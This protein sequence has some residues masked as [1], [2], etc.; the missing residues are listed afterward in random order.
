MKKYIA[1]FIV[2]SLMFCLTGCVHCKED[3][4]YT[5]EKLSECL[6]PDLP[7]LEVSFLNQENWKIYANI[8]DAE[9]ETYV[10]SV[11]D[12]LKSQNFAYLGTRGHQKSSLVG[13]FA[14]YYFQPAETLEQHCQ[15]GVYYFIYSDGSTDE[16][17]QLIFWC[18][19]IYQGSSYKDYDGK[20][21]NYNT[22]LLLRKGGE[23]PATG[24]YYYD[25]A[26][27]DPC[28]FKCSYDEGIAYPI[29]GSEETVTIRTCANCGHEDYSTFAG[30]MTIY[31]LLEADS[32]GIHYV[33][34]HAEQAASGIL[35]RIYT[36]ALL[37]ADIILTVNGT[38]IPKIES[39]DENAW[40]YAFIMPCADAIIAAEVVDGFLSSE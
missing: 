12:Y 40:C 22:L 3:I 27:I 19:N 36:Q 31:N 30:N 23:A 2:L 9:F 4:W 10:Q 1:L 29:P 39:Q 21:F 24:F 20:R 7:K 33:R 34:R 35:I 6:V 26:H 11:Y 13:A 16:G 8:K 17:G 38:A 15:N 18:L 14:S 37:D 32:S 5:E 28:F 25:E